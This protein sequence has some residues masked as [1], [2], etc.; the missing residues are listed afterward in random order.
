MPSISTW[1]SSATSWRDSFIV[2]EAG[3]QVL[4]DLAAD[5]VGMLD[6][7]IQLPILLEPLGR[8]LRPDLVDARNVVRGIAGQGQQIGDP[9]RADAEL[10]ATAAGS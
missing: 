9:L 10:L 8:G 4:A 7:L 6:Q 1:S 5:L 3:A 2:I